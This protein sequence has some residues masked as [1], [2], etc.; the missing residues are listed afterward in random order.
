MNASAAIRESMRLRLMLLMIGIFI[1]AAAS[2][3]YLINRNSI[4]ELEEI[5]N[6]NLAQSTRA[7]YQVLKDDIEGGNTDPLQKFA[8]SYAGLQNL[9]EEQLSQQYGDSEYER[10]EQLD[11]Q[12]QIYIHVTNTEKNI[13]INSRGQKLVFPSPVPQGYFSLQ[14][15]DQLWHF[16]SVSNESDT[17]RLSMG[18]RADHRDELLS[19]ISETVFV[20]MFI[21]IPFL[22][23]AL[24]WG[25]GRGIRPLRRLS[26]EIA[27]RESD[28]LEPITDQHTT[29]E[30]RP[31][32]EALNALLERLRSA[33]ASE[34]RF[35]ADA[36]HELRT[37]IAS[38][39]VQ[40]DVLDRARD[41]TEKQTAIDSMSKSTDRMSHLVEDLLALAR[42]DGQADGLNLEPVDLRAVIVDTIADMAFSALE[43]EIEISLEGDQS[44]PLITNEHLHR[45][46]FSNLLSNAIKY[47]PAGG[48]VEVTLIK[49]SG[50]AS[51][52]VMDSGPGIEAGQ[53]QRITDRFYRIQDD[54]SQH[55]AGAGL[56]LSIANSAAELL[57]ADLDFGN[58]QQGGLIATFAMPLAVGADSQSA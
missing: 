19:E 22:A 34:R 4:H 42:L 32:V 38:I 9:T 51:Y 27:R 33:L 58:R 8:D 1:V 18:Q 6:A 31:V 55:I 12:R 52:S 44:L 56:G 35:T 47:T 5:L 29:T 26:A 13:D 46:I 54:A 2:A 7:I 49:H 11:Y 57:G 25:S 24:W 37:P 39:Q 20:P 3:G 36:S 41:D 16:Y 53:L 28:N 21:V 45:L 14:E 23:L 30:T 15:N 10:A 17:S 48:T 40:L 43:R 50:A